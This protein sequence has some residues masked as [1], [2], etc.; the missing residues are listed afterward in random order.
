M[1][2]YHATVIGAPQSS[3]ALR[4]LP[5]FLLLFL[6]VAPHAARAQQRKAR[7]S[8]AKA[9]ATAPAASAT[10]AASGG[11]APA[12]APAEERA[13][14]ARATSLYGSPDGGAMAT[15]VPGA[16]GRVLARSGD[17]VRV[18]LDGWVRE[19][20]LRTGGD[21]V[22]TGVT[23]A[24]V[25]ANPERYVGKPV[26]WRLQLI[27][28]QT[29]DELRPEMPPGSPYL[30]TRGPLPEPGFVYVMVPAQSISRFKAM[31]PLAELR[32]RGTIR[33]ARSKYLATPILQLDSLAEPAGTR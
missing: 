31:G 10:S 3:P 19:S 28:I 21:G 9:R 32:V 4:R 20:D 24:E 25:R 16:S 6:L 29:A 18:Q 26:E 2:Y 30:L 5:A 14:V 17:W 8:A 7:T 15:V 11:A 13:E 23:A 1:L 12:P 22:L 27:G 33:A